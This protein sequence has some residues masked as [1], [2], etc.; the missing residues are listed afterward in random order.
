M[1]KP[2]WLLTALVLLAM[3]ACQTKP[4]KIFPE[5]HDI[6]G[7]ASPIRLDGDTT[8]IFLQ[9]FFLDGSLNAIDSVT[10]IPGLSYQLSGN[11]QILDII[12][13]E[14]EIPFL[15]EMKVWLGPDAFSFFVERSQKQRHQFVFDPQGT[16]YS[17]VSIRGDMTSWMELPLN[18]IDGKW[19]VRLDLNP[20]SYHYLLVANGKDMTDPTNPVLID[21][22]A[23]GHN[24]VLSISGFN[25]QQT[26]HFYTESFAG[27]DLVLGVNNQADEIFVFWENFRLPIQHVSRH[28]NHLHVNIPGDASE[29]ER[30]FLRI[31]GYNQ[32]GPSNDLLIPLQNGAPVTDAGTLTREDK[33][34]TILY[35]MMVDRFNNG[36]T[37]IDDPVEDPEVDQKANFY[38]GDLDGITQKIEEGYFSSLGI[39]TIW[40]SPITQ[41][42][43]EAYREYPA[44]HR[45]FTG[46]HGYWPITLTTVDHRFGDA[47]AMHRMVETAH[48][49]DIS[50]MLDFVSNHVHQENPLIKEHPEWATELN[51]PDGRRNLRLWDEQRLTTWFDEFLPSLDYSNPEVVKVMTDSA[52]FWIEE[53]KLD[54]FRHDATKHIPQEFWRA[55]TRKLKEDHM[56]PKGQRLF[57]IGETFGNRELIGSYVGSGLLD[58]QFDF[59]LYF[60]ARSAFAIDKVSFKMLDFSLHQTFNQYGF[61]HLMGN[62]TGNHDMARFISLAGGGLGFDEDQSEAGWNRNVGVG[63]PVGYDKLASLTAFIMTIPGVPVIYYG[64]E[65]GL[66]GAGDPD[67]R[68]PMKFDNL[69]DHEQ[70]LKEK[71]SKMAN[72]RNN[73][74]VFVYGD[75]QTLLA[76]DEVY[77]YARSY[78]GQTGLVVFNKSGE[79]KTISI[80]LSQRLSEP[81]YNE[82]FGS[83]FSFKDNTLT[84]TLP[85]NSFEVLTSEYKPK[86]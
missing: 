64:D 86:S 32:A 67:S 75:F 56:A 68:R 37:A 61:V 50:V 39:N 28:E 11:K 73:Y 24:S 18:L 47:Q 65:I 80:A 26:P 55:L 27:N 2:I 63:D 41:N 81:F 25:R 42:P 71:T 40:L 77:A 33:E 79:E 3:A 17:S 58:G 23:G 30:S 69:S 22:N 82:H 15:S 10:G 5:R 52:F 14:K 34:K 29:K 12:L 38:G 6:Y 35:F 85:A 20:G 48:N 54:G 8:Q 1:K 57:Q 76:E 31:R 4:V 45:K 19:Q 70:K 78:F 62:I 74:P 83:D 46:Y 49:S 66:P 36:N 51:L 53:F 59:N 7:L 21:N 84:L 44:P 60:D 13:K 9:D 72:L 16:R 43:Y